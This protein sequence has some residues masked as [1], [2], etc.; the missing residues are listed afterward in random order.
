MSAELPHGKDAAIASVV[1]D[2]PEVKRYSLTPH[3]IH[4]YEHVVGVVHYSYQATVEPHGTAPLAVTGK[5][6]EVYLRQNH[7]WVM[8]AVSGRP[9]PSP[10]E[11]RPKAEPAA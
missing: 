6:T 8:V 7:A 4:V 5:W 1:G 2:A 9:D 10:R 11:Q 3:S